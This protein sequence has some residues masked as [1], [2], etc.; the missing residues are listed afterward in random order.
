VDDVTTQLGMVKISQVSGGGNHPSLTR[1]P[2]NNAAR[3]SRRK[4]DGIYPSN[5]P[6]FDHRM[7]K[8]NDQSRLDVNLTF[9]REIKAILSKLTPQTYDKVQKQLEAL[10]VDQFERLEGMVIILF[11]K[12]T[13]RFPIWH[14]VLISVCL[15]GCRRTCVQFSLRTSM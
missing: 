14:C 2:N 11:S 7:A 9:F 10:E 4:T 5:E 12:V 1:Y 8:P 6:D 13:S 15:S 3:D